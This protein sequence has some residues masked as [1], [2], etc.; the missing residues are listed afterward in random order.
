MAL[1][2][3]YLVFLPSIVSTPLAGRLIARIGVRNALWVG[4]ATAGVG[5]PG[6]VSGMLAEM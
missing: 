3:V 2:L 1:G 5:L 4:F 6:F